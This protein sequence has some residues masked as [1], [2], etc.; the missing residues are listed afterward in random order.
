LEECGYQAA[1]EHD[2][3]SQFVIGNGFLGV[4]GSLEQPTIISRPRTFIAGLFDVP[5][6]EPLVPALVP[7]PDWLRFDLLVAGAPLALES[8]QTLAHGRTVDFQRGVLIGEWRQRDP[9]GRVV[10]VRTLRF[11]SL[12]DR[13][14]AVQIA[15]IA[16]EEPTPLTLEAWLE[17]PTDQLHPIRATP[18]LRVWRTTHTNKHLAVASHMTLRL[19]GRTI[20]PAADAEG[21][22]V[23][24]WHATPDRPAT[25]VRIVAYTRGT[26]EDDGGA[27]A[28]AALRKAR[29]AGFRRLLAA[30]ARA[31]AERWRASDVVVDGD[32]AAQRALRFALYHLISAANPDDPHTSIGARALTGDAYLGHVFWDTEIFLLPYFTCTW[33]AAARALLMYRW[34]TLP[35][36]RAKAAQLGYRGA[37]Y[38]WESA[39]TGEEAT[40]AY[41]HGPDGQLIA[42]RCGTE[43]QH[44]SADVAYAVWQYWRATEDVPLLR[45]AGAEILLETARF[46]ASRAALE[47]DGR[48]HIRG[49]IG[50]DEYHE[51]IDDNAYTNGMA[52]WNIERGLEVADLLQTRWPNRWAALRE[53]LGITVAELTAWRDVAERLVT[54]LDASS[55]LLEQFAGFYTLE[56]IDLAAY[57]PRAAP[58]DVL[59]GHTRTQR[60]Q[61]IKQADVTMLLA[62]L[63]ERYDAA[64]RAA[65]FRYYEP[66]CGHGSSLSPAIHALV[67]ARLGDVELAARYFQQAAAIDL[68]HTLGNAASGV[69]IATLGGLWQAAVLGFGGLSFSTEGIRCEPHLPEAWRSLEFPIQ[70]RGRRVRLALRQAPLTLTA[71][72]EHG[73]PLLLEVGDLRHRLLAGQPWT[74]QW[75]PAEQR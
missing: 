38:A 20:R 61:V 55:G 4:R 9:A 69:H 65:N 35:A 36:A 67:A 31:W 58:M 7:G 72:L 57:T 52:Q 63:W 22:H 48:Y 70:W 44:I 43:E 23:W 39:D 42:I 30:H 15:Q 25:L 68:D 73:Q 46:W 12:A 11:V 49:V 33:P 24:R 45:D 5:P 41:V 34:Y 54:G 51:G 14:L 64:V 37:L 8:G 28:L 40:P 71:T 6:R 53:Q 50:P 56:P 66:R 21:R 2:V 19:N 13:S 18:E 1:L 26:S 32:E 75:R 27:A 59:L 60:S 62:L 3:E 10:H 16:V 17:P 29:Q 47:A 74:Y